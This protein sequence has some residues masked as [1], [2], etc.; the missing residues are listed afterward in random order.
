MLARLTAAIAALVFTAVTATA[1]P[2]APASAAALNDAQIAHIAFT[3]GQIDIDAGKVALSKSK[4]P[5][6]IDFANNMVKDHQ[7]VN[8]QA[9][10]LLKKLNVTPQDNDT[11]KSLVAAAAAKTKELSALSGDA[12][13]KAYIANEV[14]Y[15][16]TVNGALQMTLIPGATNADLKALLMTGLKIFQGHQQHAEMLAA[17]LK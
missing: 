15:H 9:L 2:A 13:D 14:A 17:M 10:A 8:D 6:V 1:Q 4:N 5:V 7:A 11:S 3:A 16:Q 12:F